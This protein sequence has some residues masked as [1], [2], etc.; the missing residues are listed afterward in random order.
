MILDEGHKATSS[1]AR[2]T[3][4]GFNASIVVE[5]SATPPKEAN[6][7]VRVSGRELLDEEMIKLPINIANSNERSWKDCLTQAKDKKEHLAR[8]SGK[9]YRATGQVIRPIVLVQVE[10]TGKEQRI[11]GGPIHSEDAKEYLIQRLGVPETAIAIKSAATDDIEGI[12]LLDEG[13]PVEWIITK[14]ALQEGWD[15]PFAYIL[16]SLNNTG[17]ALAMTQLVGRVLRQPGAKKT[18]FTD[19]NESYVYCLRKKA[20]EITREVKSALE[21]EGYEG[22]AAAV[23]DS[24]SEGGKPRPP[25][26]ATIR[27]QFLK[28]YRKPFQGKIFI[29]RFC[30]KCGK[31]YEALDYFRHLVSRVDLNAADYGS[32]D[33]EISKILD[34]AKDSFYQ[35][36]LGQDEARRIKEVGTVSLETDDQVRSWLIASLGFDYF[37]HKQL[38]SVVAQAI[39]LVYTA[40]PRA[41]GNLALAKFQLR[42]KLVG[43]IQRETDKQTQR[44]FESLYN[45]KK[46][47]FYLECADGR[48][49]IPRHVRIE[50]TRS[51]VHDNYERPQRSLFDYVDEADFNEY[52]KAVALSLD[53]RAEV[54]WWYR[55]LVGPNN[56]SIQ[57]Y[58]RNRVYPDFVVQEGRN[59]KPTSTVLV[60]ESKGK[61][62]KGSED[63]NYKR[64]IAEYFGKVG[65]KVAWQ[66]LGEGFKDRTFRFQVL[67]EGEYGD[68]DW[69]TDLAHALEKSGG[70]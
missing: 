27:K 18:S 23:V 5:L 11:A 41:R 70:D 47:C 4:E 52:E 28:F 53:K 37:S 67:D 30:V 49:E 10:R 55:N 25:T 48:F 31:E 61:H 16:V 54:L 43:L 68:R 60:L 26:E 19:L 38:R 62:L 46:L 64:R 39:D 69:R 21:Q 15:C 40:T 22:D 33:W 1:L 44:A 63:T 17:S 7:L 24:S 12:D 42:D 13:C 29:P 32:V 34:S 66:E 50:G 51:L 58:R 65:R 8:L 9:H 59:Y 3:I 20:T 57:G 36:T 14:S 2:E 6:V 45:S 35:L 56:F